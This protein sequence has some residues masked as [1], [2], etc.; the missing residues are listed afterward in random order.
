MWFELK[1]WRLEKSG[2]FI[3][4]KACTTGFFH[5]KTASPKFQFSSPGRRTCGIFNPWGAFMFLKFYLYRVWY[6][7]FNSK[8]VDCI[9]FSRSLS[10]KFALLKI[11]GHA[12]SCPKFFLNLPS[13]EPKENSY[14][15]VLCGVPW[16]VF[17][18]FF[19]SRTSPHF[20]LQ[21]ESSESPSENYCKPAHQYCFRF[22]F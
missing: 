11:G 21:S 19:S 10:S 22:L 8:L 5:G 13:S 2:A 1:T 16:Y 15:P 4:L 12:E 18:Q 6:L 17:Y 3:L 20:S 7:I 14:H 9:F